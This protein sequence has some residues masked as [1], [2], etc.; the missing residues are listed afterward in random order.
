MAVIIPHAA[1]DMGYCYGCYNSTCCRG[2][3]LLLWLLY[4]HMLQGTWVIVMAVIFHMLQGT[5]VI[6]MAVIFHMLQGTWVIVMAVIIPH[7]AGDM[8]YC[9]GCYIPH[10]AG[11]MG[12]CYGC[13]IPHAAGDMGYCYG[14]YNSTCCRGHGL[15]LWLLYFTCCRG[16]GS[17]LWLLYFHMLQGTWVI[18]MAVIF[19]ELPNGIE[20]LSKVELIS[21][22]ICAFIILLVVIIFCGICIQRM[23]H[24][25]YGNRPYI[26]E[27]PSEAENLMIPSHTIH[28]LL[29]GY[30]HSGSGSGKNGRFIE[31]RF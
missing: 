4:F 29:D 12:Y 25:R 20:S 22:T 11:D 3:G 13:Y 14:C 19:P 2:H 31:A 15:L 10:A 6:V 16:H 9:Y 5:W 24:R 30:S 7:A 1:G 18:V 27:S 21:I 17:L 26:V 23:L 8:G 28:D